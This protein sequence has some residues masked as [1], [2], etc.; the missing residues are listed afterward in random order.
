MTVNLQAMDLNL[1]LVFQAVLEEGTTTR[2]AARLN[3]TQSA[4]SNAL[5]RMRHVVGDPLFVRSGRGLVPTPRALQMREAVADAIARLAEA[6][7][8]Q[9]DPATTTRTFTLAAADHHA[10]VDVP[11][12]AVAFA[13]AMPRACLRVVSVDYL[14]STDG[15]AS[16]T[17]DAAIAPE[18]TAGSGLHLA[19]LFRERA[20]LVARRDHPTVGDALSVDGLNAASHVDVHLALGQPGDVNRDVRG[21]FDALGHERRIALV[22]PSFTAAATA[23]AHT[24]HV[25]W[26]PSHAAR[27]FVALL[28]LRIV[29]TPLPALDV[30]CALVWHARTHG[31]PGGER[32]RAVA[33]DVL[34][35]TDPEDAG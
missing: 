2:A 21:R 14:L 27:L 23:V 22:V 11:R 1:F 29:R 20:V 9:F 7:G 8:Q 30:G 32:F 35:E 6:V 16:G 17:V 31:D 10:A 15:L 33:I 13:A 12:L 26:L 4:V 28:G 18:N 3:V 24:D 25:A 19:P 5:A 34:R